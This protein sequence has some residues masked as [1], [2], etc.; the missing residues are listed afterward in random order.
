MWYSNAGTWTPQNG[1]WADWSPTLWRCP[2]CG[3]EGRVMAADIVI[4]GGLVVD[5]TG[6]PAAP[7]RR[8]HHGRPHQ[9]HRRQ[10]RWPH[11]SRCQRLPCVAG[12]HRHPHALR[13]AGLLGSGADPVVF[14]RR[15]HCRR[16][17]LWLLDRADPARAPRVDRPDAAKGRGHGCRHAGR[18]HPVGLRDVPRVSRI[19][20]KPR[21]GAQL[22][23]LHRAHARCASTCSATRPPTAWRPT[24]RSTACRAW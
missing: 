5:G 12:L 11:R 7:R 14:S 23:G 20:R 9:R 8:G 13:R 24:T 15:H 19:G 1:R 6:A 18:R 21:H 10:P 22:R 3:A 17:Q 4:R 2:V 16:G